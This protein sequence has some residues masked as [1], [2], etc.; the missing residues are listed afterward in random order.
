MFSPVG[1]CHFCIFCIHFDIYIMNKLAILRLIFFVLSNSYT[2]IPPL[3]IYHYLGF[4]SSLVEHVWRPEKLGSLALLS[5]HSTPVTLYTSPTPLP[6]PI[7]LPHVKINTPRA[8][9]FHSDAQ[10]RRPHRALLSCSQCLCV[11]PLSPKFVHVP[12]KYL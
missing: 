11:C 4:F 9:P 2:N 1:F 3:K 8:A 7:S 12:L 10:S 6:P 5:L